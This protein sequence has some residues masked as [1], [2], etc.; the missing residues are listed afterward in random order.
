MRIVV[1]LI[2]IVV[3]CTGIE[4]KPISDIKG[5]NLSSSGVSENQDKNNISKYKTTD[6]KED[7]LDKTIS[8][9]QINLEIE[10]IQTNQPDLNNIITN[11]KVYETNS[12]NSE[13]DILE[14]NTLG[15]KD[16]IDLVK[17]K[18][19]NNEDKENVENS[20][21]IQEIIQ[22]QHD[23][24]QNLNENSSKS[25]VENTLLSEEINNF[26]EKLVESHLFGY[27]GNLYSNNTENFHDINDQEF[28]DDHF[29]E[30]Y[31]KKSNHVNK[32]DENIVNIEEKYVH[33]TFENENKNLNFTSNN[34]NFT[35]NLNPE[36]IIIAYL[37]LFA[38]TT[39]SNVIKLLKIVR[40]NEISRI[41]TFYIFSFIAIWLL[42]PMKKST[43]YK[44]TKESDL[45]S[46]KTLEKLIDD[47]YEILKSAIIQKQ[48]TLKEESSDAQY[49]NLILENLERIKDLEAGFQVQ[50][51][52]SHKEIWDAIDS[53]KLP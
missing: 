15:S 34:L 40:E 18:E 24:E 52:D 36:N 51:I 42:F 2:F 32:N 53:R 20:K 3:L 47:Q 44:I 35:S 39:E 10:N 30:T 31:E 19:G 9:S 48:P 33:E 11:T 7:N 41:G 26:E 1:W 21:I 49:L 27:A 25:D 45:S 37:I 5:K 29:H 46:A 4:D 16:S 23:N 14:Q 13:N 17:N 6:A 43:V 28:H 22:E 12:L 8:K 38:E 50:V